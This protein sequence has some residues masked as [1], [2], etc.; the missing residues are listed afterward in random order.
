MKGIDQILTGIAR[1][2]LNIPTLATRNSDSL[3]FH[4][5]SAS[6]IRAALAAA[7]EAGARSAAGAAPETLAALEYVRAVLKLRHLDE[8]SD[9]EVEEA[10]GMADAAITAARATGLPSS[11]PDPGLPARFDDYEVHGVREFDDGHGRYCEQ[12]PDEQAEF[13]S[14]YGHIPGQGVD[15]IGD[16]KTREHAEEVLARITGRCYGSGSD[17]TTGR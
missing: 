15:C 4:D 10:L 1:R 2:H 3:D 14:L 13:W 9:D 5:V 11:P 7:Y 12:V 6:G 17:E 8:A 16:F